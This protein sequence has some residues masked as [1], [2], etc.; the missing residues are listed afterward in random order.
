MAVSRQQQFKPA[1]E[2]LPWPGA[3]IDMLVLQCI[4]CFRAVL[5]NGGVE[6]TT[7]QED[8][9]TCPLDRSTD[10]N[11]SL[12]ML[13]ELLCFNRDCITIQDGRGMTAL[14]LLQERHEPRYRQVPTRQNAKAVLLKLVENY[15][16]VPK[17]PSEDVTALI[18]SHPACAASSCT[19]TRARPRRFYSASSIESQVPGYPCCDC[20]TIQ[21]GRRMT[22]LKLLEEE[23]IP[24]QDKVTRQNAKIV[25]LKLAANYNYVPKVPNDATIAILESHS[26]WTVL[27]PRLEPGRD[28]FI[29]HHALEA[30]CP[31]VPC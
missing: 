20:M 25:L 23:M 8:G 14:E 21:D 7:I 10:P 9:Q 24:Q 13:W 1:V 12:A 5:Y 15:N 2:R 18:E 27:A 30:K 11:V 16:H 3:P 4:D 26:V 28:A 17:L 19:A 29:L 6:A 22:A 31:H